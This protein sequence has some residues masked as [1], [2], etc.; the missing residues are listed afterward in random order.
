MSAEDPPRPLGAVGDFPPG[1][2]R[3]VE[4]A[5]F[6]PLAVYNVDGRLFATN[7]FCTHGKASLSEGFLD[8]EIIECPYHGG[9]FNVR[10]GAPAHPPCVIAV[11]TWRVIV[12]DGL[13]VL[14]P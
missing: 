6:P 3:R 4:L 1:E 10:T 7:D 12:R 2:V 14:D 5:G 13:A 8:G 9:R 11:R